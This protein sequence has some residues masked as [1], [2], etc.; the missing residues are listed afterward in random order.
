MRILSARTCMLPAL[1]TY[2][3]FV[4]PVTGHG[5]L[6]CIW[7]VFFGFECPGCGLSRANALLVHGFVQDAVASNCLIAPVWFV[8]IY[9]FLSQLLLLVKQRRQAHG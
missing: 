3:W 1:M 2:G 8:A 6:P 4:N 5:G 7:R 9:S